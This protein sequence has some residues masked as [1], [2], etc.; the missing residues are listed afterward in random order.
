MPRIIDLGKRSDNLRG[1]NLI[2]GEGLCSNIYVM[3]EEQVTMV[4]AGVGNKANPVW[5]QL[6]E[7]GIEPE[8]LESMIITHAHHDH[9]M[10]LFLIL[11]RAAPKVYMHKN[12][13][14]QIASRI[15]GNLV[16]VGEGDEIETEVWPL[17]V[18]WTPGHTEGGISLYAREEKILFSGDTVFPGGNFG[19]FDGQT[20]SLQEIKE[21]LRK[22][23]DLEVEY[24]LPGHGMPAL[25]EGSRHIELAYK[26]ASQ[27]G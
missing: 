13:T 25:E 20:G 15:G 18:I 17:E 14:R 2:L 27:W 8:N 3:G 9:A 1:L 26:S 22:L 6:K 10:G 5:P 21:S 12:S 11:E 24:L 16:E 4:D 23:R 19:R 7:I